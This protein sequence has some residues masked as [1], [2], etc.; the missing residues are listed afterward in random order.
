[1]RLRPAVLDDVEEVFVAVAVVVVVAAAF[2]AITSASPFWASH[3][4]LAVRY[5]EFNRNG[6]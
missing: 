6:N 4:S 5:G 3:S 1:M 2:V